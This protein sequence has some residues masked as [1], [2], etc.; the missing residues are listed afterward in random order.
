MGEQAREK[1]K[2]SKWKAS[3]IGKAFR[4]G[5]KPIPGPAGGLPID[6]EVEATIVTSEEEEGLIRE[7]AA[8]G[9]P[10][11][12]GEETARDTPAQSAQSINID[13]DELF[14]PATPTSFPSAV[15]TPVEDERP[16]TPAFPT[17]LNTP[18][19]SSTNIPTAFESDLDSASPSPPI[20]R[21]APP[22]HQTA[23]LFPPSPVNIA[24]AFPAAVFPS[25]PTV[26]LTQSYFPSSPDPLPSPTVVPV[27][28]SP[29]S[30]PTPTASDAILPKTLDPA[31]IGLIQKHAKW[32]IS[33]LNYDDLDTARKELRAALVM[34]DG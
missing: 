4:E 6:E 26:P 14:L 34:L 13:R 30:I 29:A 28:R 20:V 31:T 18:T 5:R 32:A 33:A 24:A 11:E 22:S 25:A 23:D 27:A 2:Y 15:P 3:D 17:F 12:R 10:D 9:T 19:P 7:L 1:I 16:V 8:L 21:V